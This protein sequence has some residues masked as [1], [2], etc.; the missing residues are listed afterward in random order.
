MEATQA[1]SLSSQLGGA[2]VLILEE[3]EKATEYKTTWEWRE[4]DRLVPFDMLP[5]SGT[6]HMLHLLASKGF[7]VRSTVRGHGTYF[8]L[9]PDWEMK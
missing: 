3:M 1:V 2:A 9:A 5:A 7:L 8:R 6:W 4:I